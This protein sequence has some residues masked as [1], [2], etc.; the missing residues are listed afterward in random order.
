LIQEFPSISIA[1]EYVSFYKYGE[2]DLDDLFDNKI[3]LITQEN[4]KKLIETAK[5]DEYK[6]FYEDNY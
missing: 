6:L 2:D 3:L 5:F 1:N 4:L